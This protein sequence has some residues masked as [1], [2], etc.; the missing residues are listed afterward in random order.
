MV[1]LVH[2]R[3]RKIRT[4]FTDKIDI[5]LARLGQDV[6][7]GGKKTFGV[8]WQYMIWRYQKIL[9]QKIIYEDLVQFRNLCRF[10]LVWFLGDKMFRYHQTK[11]WAIV[12]DQN[13]LILDSSCKHI[14]IY[15]YIYNGN[16][17]TFWH[18]KLCMKTWY[19][20]KSLWILTFFLVWLFWV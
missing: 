20:T 3:R 12:L 14:Y 7:R 1:W 16:I 9:G 18:R 5:K 4:K 11:I 8:R 19:N 2:A 10:F 15:I 13:V 6:D 17:R